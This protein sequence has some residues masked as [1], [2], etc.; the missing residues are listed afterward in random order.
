MECVRAV[1]IILGASPNTARTAGGR[2]RPRYLVFR[3]PHLQLDN[4]LPINY[5]YPRNSTSSDSGIYYPP[6]PATSVPLSALRARFLIPNYARNSRKMSVAR[7]DIYGRDTIRS[8]RR[9]TRHL[10]LCRPS[11]RFVASCNYPRF[12]EYSRFIEYSFSFFFPVA[13]E[14]RNV[15]RDVTTM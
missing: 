4:A 9:S 2:A 12:P 7:L 13:K 8:Q 1:I 10:S 3:E 6:S 11:L 14:H 15:T 5:I